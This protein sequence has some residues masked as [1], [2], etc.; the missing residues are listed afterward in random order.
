MLLRQLDG[1]DTLVQRSLLP[2]PRLRGKR[3]GAF[4]G[5]YGSIWVSTLCTQNPQ[6]SP[7]HVSMWPRLR[8]GRG[9]HRCNLHRRTL[10]SPTITQASKF[11]IY[12]FLKFSITIKTKT[13]ALIGRIGIYAGKQSKQM[14]L[15]FL[16]TFTKYFFF[17]FV[18]LVR[19]WSFL[20]QNFFL[21]LP[22]KS[23]YCLKTF[24][25]CYRCQK[26]SH[27]KAKRSTKPLFRH[28]ERPTT[29]IG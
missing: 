20:T 5:G 2:F 14:I 10:E 13:R 28:L 29:S 22:P 25:T 18:Q 23:Q 9:A 1:N 26:T 27:N 8:A 7:N 19:P 16:Q 15:Y 6:Q 4:S 24:L 12:G 21:R 11:W 3:E 17:I